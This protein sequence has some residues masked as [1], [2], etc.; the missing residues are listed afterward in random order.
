MAD[1]RVTYVASLIADVAGTDPAQRES[2][3]NAITQDGAQLAPIVALVDKP[4]ARGV[5]ALVDGSGRVSISPTPFKDAGKTAYQVA[6]AKSVAAPLELRDVATLISIS[7]IGSNPMAALY[8]SLV[9]VYGPV[10]DAI[11]GDRG[12]A[13]LLAE[14]RDTVGH[15]LK[16]GPPEGTVDPNATPVTVVATVA[17][18]LERWAALAAR[19]PGAADVQA[20]LL[21][22]KQRLQECTTPPDA[23]PP[24]EEQLLELVDAANSCLE[25]AWKANVGPYPAYDQ[26]HMAHML[27][28]LGS[29]LQS[30]LRRVVESV[31]TWTGPFDAVHPTL[32]GVFNVAAQAQR[33]CYELESAVFNPSYDSAGEARWLQSDAAALA[34]I[35]LYTHLKDRCYEIVRLRETVQEMTMLVGVDVPPGEVLAPFAPLDPL[36]VGPHASHLWTAARHEFETRLQ[37][38]EARASQKIREL[39]TST[40]TPA[41]S[42]AEASGMRP[43]DVLREIHGLKHLLSRPGVGGGL[44]D[45]VDALA[46]GIMRYL[47]FLRREADER[48]SAAGQGATPSQGGLNTTS[49]VDALCWAAQAQLKVTQ[50]DQAARALVVQGAPPSPAVQSLL[51]AARKAEDRVK[52]L[53][54]TAVSDWADQTKEI[55]SDIRHERSA[56]LLQMSSKDG[57]FRPGFNDHLFRLLREVRQL[58]SLGYR[59]PRE[60]AVEM[61]RAREFYKTGMTLKQIANCYNNL[62]SQILP[63]IK[64]MLLRAAEE[65]EQLMKSPTDLSGAKITWDSHVALANYLDSL[66]RAQ[67]RFSE[68]QRRLMHYHRE[69]RDLV[70]TLSGADLGASKDRWKEGIRDMR[71][72]FERLEGEFDAGAQRAWRRHWDMQ[73]KKVVALQYA[74]GLDRLHESLPREEV[75]LEFRQGRL[76]LTPSL[77]EV[78]QRHYKHLQDFI[79]LPLKLKG[80]SDLSATDGFFADVVR[81]HA[82]GISDAYRASEAALDELAAEAEK[83]RDWLALGSVGSVDEFVDLHIQSADTDQQSFS[84]FFLSNAAALKEASKQAEDERFLPSEVVHGCFTL[85]LAPVKQEFSNQVRRLQ[86]SMNGALT[87][88]ARAERAEIEEYLAQVREL[89]D[90]KAANMEEIGSHKHKAEELMHAMTRV[91]E[92]KIKI[93]E[94][95]K[96]LRQMIA[97]NALPTR[98]GADVGLVDISDLQGEID[99]NFDKLQQFDLHIGEQQKGLQAQALKRKDGLLGKIEGAWAEWDLRRP[100]NVQGRDPAMIFAQMDQQLKMLEELETHAAEVAKDCENCGVGAADMPDLERLEALRAEMEEERGAWQRYKD[101]IEERDSLFDASWLSVREQARNKLEDFQLKWRGYLKEQKQKGPVDRAIMEQLEKYSLIDPHLRYIQG[102]SWDDSHWSRLF[103]MI[104]LKK[105]DATK[106]TLLHFLDRADALAQNAEAIKAMDARAQ[107]EAGLRKAVQE[108]KDWG[109]DRTFTLAEHTSTGGGQDGRGRA[110]MLIREWKDL[111]S[112][113]ADLQALVGSLKQSPYFQDSGIRDDTLSWEARLSTLVGALGTLNGIQRRWVYL[114][115]IFSRGALPHEQPRFARVDRDFVSLMN[116]IQRDPHVKAFADRPGLEAQLKTMAD[117]LEHCQKSL[118]EFLEDRRA[119]FPRFYFIG[120]DDLLEILSQ[121]KDPNVIQAHLK[122]LFAGI[123]RVVLKASG[124]RE[125]TITHMCSADGEEV[126]LSP[127]VR[128][129]DSV[130]EWLSDLSAS[131]KGTLRERLVA[132]TL[133]GGALRP[134]LTPEDFQHMPSQVLCVSDAVRFTSRAEEAIRSNG[135]LTLRQELDGELQGLTDASYEGHHVMQLKVKAMILDIIHYKDVVESLIRERCQTPTEWAWFKQLRFY[136]QPDGQCHGRMA[137]SEIEYTFEYQGNAPKLV[138]TPLTDRCFLTLTQALKLG[139]GGN[140]YGPAGTGKTESVKALGQYLARQVLVFN[141]DEEFDFRSMGRIFVGLVKCGAWGCFDEFNRLEQEVLSAVSQQIQQIQSSIK[142]RERT[143]VFMGREIPVDHNAGIFVTMNPAGKGYGGR[144]KLPDNLKALFRPIAMSVPDDELIAEVMLLAEGF[145]SARALSRRVVTL[146]RVSRQLLSKQQHYDWGLRAL[147]TVLG[148]AGKLLREAKAANPGVV[149]T[150]EQEMSL[151]IRA[152]RVTTLPKLTQSD[153]ERF[154][155]LLEVQFRGAEM[156]DVENET[157]LAAIRKV[158]ER[159]SL[160]PQDD[161]VGKILQLDMATQQRT[162]VIIVGPSGCGKSTLWTVLEAAYAELG[163]PVIVHRM[164]PKAVDRKQLLGSLDMDTREWT[165]GVLTAAARR[166]VQEP[167]SQRSWIVCD[168]DVDPEWIESLNSVMDDNRLLT[169]PNGE[170]IQLG[171]NVNFVFECHSLQYA[172]P[173]TVSRCGM[174][175]MS[176]DAI[177]ISN[178]VTKW[179]ADLEKDAQRREDGRAGPDVALLRKWC[180]ELLVR[181]M[182]VAVQYQPVVPTTTIGQLRNVLSHVEHATSRAEFARGLAHGLGSNVAKEDRARL[183]QHIAQVANERGL[184]HALAGATFETLMLGPDAAD[185]LAPAGGEDAPERVVPTESVMRSAQDIAPWLRDGAPFILCGESGCGKSALLDRMLDCLPDEIEVARVPCSASTSAANV[186]G[187]LK[188]ICGKPRTTNRGKVLAPRGAG[189]VILHLKDVNLPKPDRYGTVQLVA[190]LQQILTY[191]G[192]YD[193]EEGL[194]WVQIERIQIVGTMDPP[195][196]VG[197]HPLSQRLA[198]VMRIA[199]MPNPT[200]AELQ[201]IFARLL[202]PIVAHLRGEGG[203]GVPEPTTLAGAMV[204]V[205][206]EVK[207]VFTPNERRHYVFSPRQLSQ[208]AEALLHYDMS[209]VPAANAVAYEACRVFQDCIVDDAGQAQLQSIVTSTLRAAMRHDPDLSGVFTLG[210][211]PLSGR[212]HETLGW[213]DLGS[214]RTLV[215]EKLRIFDREVM[216]ADVVLFEQFLRMVAAVERTLTRPRGALLL[217]GASGTGRKLSVLLAAHMLRLQVFQPKMVK[218]YGI[219]HFHN[220]L[221]AAMEAA[222]LRNEPAL[223]LLE[224]R[225]VTSDLMLECLNA[226][227]SSGEV[228]GLLSKEDH[229]RLVAPLEKEMQGE[230]RS[231]LDMFVH[232]VRVNLRVALCANP[233]DARFEA[234]CTSNPALLSRCNV[235][236]VS[237]WAPSSM[238]EV[239]VARLKSSMDTSSEDR[240]EDLVQSALT[241]FGNVAEDMQEPRR[242]C[243]LVDCYVKIFASR[244]AELREQLG[245]MRAGMDKLREAGDTVDKLSRDAVEKEGVLKAKQAEADAALNNITRAMKEAEKRKTIVAELSKKCASDEMVIQESKR[246][247]EVELSEVQPMIDA[248]RAAVNSIKK[249]HLNE[250]RSLKMPPDAIRDVMEGVM[251]LLGERDT[252]WTGMRAFLGRSGMKEQIINFDAHRIDAHIREAVLRLMQAKNSFEPAVIQ[253]VS[254]AA[255]PLATWVRANI[256]YSIVLEKVEPLETK[257][258]EHQADLDAAIEKRD[259]A[260]REMRE[261]E[262]SIDGLK[263]ECQRKN[264]EAAMLSEELRRAKETL[265]KAT[266]LLD[267]LKDERGRWKKQED[268]LGGALV[269]LPMRALASA[270]F[271]TFLLREPEDVR[272]EWMESWCQI[273]GMDP[274]AFELRRFM[275]SERETLGWKAEGLPGDNLSV[276]N[277]IAIGYAAQAPFIIDPSASA[278]G[279]LETNVRKRGGALKVT[280]PHMANF[281]N[282]LELAVRFGEVLIVRDVDSV[283]PILFPILRRDML[284]QGPRPVVLVGDKAI[285]YNDGFRVFLFTRNSDP[286]LPPQAAALLS[287]TNFSVTRAGLEAQLLAAAIQHELPE[288]EDKKSALLKTEEDLTM[289]LADLERDL[290]GALARS[291]GNILENRELL[292]TLNQTKEKSQAVTSSLEESQRLQQELDKQRNAYKQLASLGSA[293]YF[294]LRDLASMSYMYRFSLPFFLTI[295]KRTMKK[296]PAGGQ[297]ADTRV[298]R[299]QL[300]LLADVYEDVARGLFNDDRLTFAMHMA[301]ALTRLTAVRKVARE[302]GLAPERAP[303]LLRTVSNLRSPTK[304]PSM[305]QGFAE[306][307][308]LYNEWQVLM[309]RA[310]GAAAPRGAQTPQWVAKGPA[311]AAYAALVAAMPRLEYEYSLSDSALWAPWFASANPEDKGAWPD[312]GKK[313]S[314][315]HRLLL[316]QALRPDRL[317]SAMA[318]YARSILGIK[319]VDPPAVPMTHLVE[320]ASATSPLLFLLTP[321]AD[322]SQNLLEVASR[323]VGSNQYEEIAMGQGQAEAALLQLRECA[324]EGRWLCLKNVHLVVSWLPE[325]EKEVYGLGEQVH[326]NFRLFL[327]SEPHAAFPT[328]LLEHCFKVTYEAPPGLRNNISR[329]LNDWGAE[330]LQQGPV[331]RAR[332][333]FALAWFHAIVQERRAYVPLGWC[334]LYEFSNADLR[335]GADIM[336]LGTADGRPV[337]WQYL[338][339]LLQT[340]VYGGRVDNEADSR[341]LAELLDSV[342]NAATIQG[343]GGTVA[344][345]PGTGGAVRVPASASLADM[346]AIVSALDAN[347]AP[348]IFL[349]PANVNRTR[350][351]VAS[352]RVVQQMRAMETSKEAAA[353]FDPEVW[354]EKLGPLLRAW[355]AMVAGSTHLQQLVS[356][357]QVRRLPS[358]LSSEGHRKPPI[359]S[360]MMLELAGAAR[361]VKMVHG[362]ISALNRV[363]N[364]NAALTASVERDGRALVADEIP[365]AWDAEWEGTGDPLSYVTAVGRKADAVQA[366]VDAGGF[367]GAVTGVSFR[368]SGLFNPGAFLNALRQETA[369]KLGCPMDDLVLRGAWTA[370]ALGSVPRELMLPVDGI[371]IEGATFDGGR[372]AEV[373]SDAP[374]LS[375]L[376]TT[377]LAWIPKNAPPAY[378]ATVEMPL[379]HNSTRAAVLCTL[380]LPVAD[381]E[382]RRRWLL[383][384]SALLLEA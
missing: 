83:R 283:D 61:D 202:E 378:K 260:E 222:G 340:A 288:L 230:F 66:Q 67:E 342:F 95:N 211:T 112:E 114:E 323:T 216:A 96:L 180:D 332:L 64:P 284:K 254:R 155:S 194:E 210:G 310:G 91:R 185:Q 294:V 46:E 138:Y 92:L 353:N 65:L 12:A 219:R 179:L 58:Q 99:T 282:S 166:V 335:S 361:L 315:F 103:G 105:I 197:R 68:K 253:R 339:G 360:M 187:K 326:P 298:T 98:G 84:R 97:A 175:F 319:S 220:D 295:F 124:P 281:V 277:A 292:E 338:H 299:L 355:S 289:Q 18:E 15:A 62:A 214:Y 30:C 325:L 371:M 176:D 192:Y 191:R 102:V 23:A 278:L 76:Q 324:R 129:T 366:L 172:S 271:I 352:A 293:L 337:D 247:V 123:Y 217:V 149:P 238:E 329:T 314:S 365:A 199:Y 359:E 48:E 116:Q 164:N 128:V 265:D 198:A 227:L 372:L 383:T 206:E 309:S 135:L 305:R 308:Q 82:E 177:D 132:C 381:K 4:D 158:Y 72:I 251:C 80:V 235:I 255:A 343:D 346:K 268:D 375:E 221:K 24:S 11:G 131:M 14:F 249:D 43:Q 344:P 122:K 79:A 81:G 245:N 53:S 41:L 170:R 139:N 178:D 130:E 109:F 36:S 349:L 300:V 51:G 22:L 368:L 276:D 363:L 218:G 232:R 348:S 144:S 248:A 374:T 78:R 87:R 204:A 273:L 163:R 212:G 20:L 274:G 334:K 318:T 156:R 312:V 106:V 182:E 345:L 341:I 54:R 85:S 188:S 275:S 167:Q 121:C 252:S 40:Y 117:Q 25:A 301:R 56:Q 228:L 229:E 35:D 384:G 169:L 10:V 307:D 39:L 134:E 63:C 137:G 104:G 259:A 26:A 224:D 42:G 370:G 304:S 269:E 266:H 77:E 140:P 7:V 196:T 75:T 205:Y 136:A 208:W 151:V 69:L 243:A 382:A 364:S 120:D 330:Y 2:V 44:A 173:A 328:S 55:L 369:A 362:A 270:A 256:K 201:E 8:A 183:T 358:R 152:V 350:E 142:A 181:C 267:M 74:S 165:D 327:T 28:V 59:V 161:Q 19:H 157:L 280:A 297:Q 200:G 174:I 186:I 351:Q 113:A 13:K 45:E 241:L 1:P 236:W 3:L 89:V 287:V 322:P 320:K 150:A 171:D 153:L 357:K 143:M 257:L 60:I 331:V 203:Q 376:P 168:G 302:R 195:S 9:N 93:D 223:L 262:A 291:T 94:K 6:I 286:H 31:D 193:E 189:R 5:Y 101:F 272:V 86:D 34:R 279:W 147:K 336:S 37:P 317:R 233:A 27:H 111:L 231:P 17:E 146:F 321:G 88:T 145:R 311:E 379:Y 115:P 244:R 47:D 367:S 73:L 57:S 148:I 160:V 100:G 110:M 226:L 125:H 333:L 50:V 380:D 313:I 264:R 354:R 240:D 316:V 209:T 285:D 29:F 154:L 239:A 373:G 162:G 225:Q 38:F 108:L 347:D 21:P 303:S 250:V 290:L 141:C 159:R 246:G 296:T 377:T 71:R 234:R 215:A 213:L 184:E 49:T 258:A 107:A 207:K 33:M 190:L 70:V 133:Q 119:V 356:G 90:S 263:E 242:L 127:P 52:L 16:S 126:A 237:G 32:Q 118:M 306:L 261:L